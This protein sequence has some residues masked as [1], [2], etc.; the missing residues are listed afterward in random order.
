MTEAP[1]SGEPGSSPPGFHQS[2]ID[3]FFAKEFSNPDVGRG[4]RCMASF[5]APL[6]LGL[7]GRLPVEMIFA[8]M[9]AQNLANVDVRGSY[10]LRFS[11]LMAMSVILAASAALGALAAPSLVAC[12]LATVAIGLGATLWRHLS[13]DY[14]PSLAVASGFLCFIAMVEK[15]GP[16]AAESH[17]VAAL[18]GGLW[19]AFLHVAFWPIR[20]QHALR[21]AVGASW[22]AVADS[23][24]LQAN[25]AKEASLR[26]ILD[27]TRAVLSS[28]RARRTRGVIER[29]DELN[30]VAARL[31]QRVSSFQSAW[32][33]VAGLPM[34]G[35]LRSA[36]ENVMSVTANVARAVAL[37]VVSRQPGQLGGAEV[38]LR[39]LDHLVGV[40]R[41][42]VAERS[43]AAGWAAVDT[44]AAQ[45]ASYLP[46]L[47]EALR[48][49]VD[50][51]GDQG[52]FSLE[53]LDLAHQRLRPLAA[54]L[55][56]NRKVDPALVRYAARITVLALLGVW[57]MKTLALKHGYWLPFTA[58]VVLQPDYGS[59]RIRATQR[60]LGTLAGSILASF[61]LWLHLPFAWNMAATA[62]TAFGFG[63][64]LRRNY[65]IAVIYITLFV[66]V[67]TESLGPVTL[68]LTIERFCDTFAGGLL[69]LLAA[70]LFWPAWEEDR[71]RPVLAKALNANARYM[72]IVGER[73]A[74]GM[75]YDSEVVN[76]KRASESAN[77]EA[78]SSLQRMSGDPKNYRERLSELAVVAN[79]NQRVTRSLSLIILQSNPDFPIL[80]ARGISMERAEVLEGMAR[81]LGAADTP[82]VP[83]SSSAAPHGQT[84][85]PFA[86]ERSA[87][88]VIALGQLERTKAEVGAMAVAAAQLARSARLAPAAN[89]A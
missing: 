44:T 57:A 19:G 8:A 45:L 74:T 56:L 16:A 37:A 76:A 63:F 6:A 13:S 28:T 89:A 26:T 2:L 30:N 43:D 84:G 79:G 29:L 75:P 40:F 59:T 1:N 69:A 34:G 48:G 77:A 7:S 60:L 50:R 31:G 71:F 20:P 12:L 80:E 67:L 51:A 70:L 36:A 33:E 78:F 38:R 3:Q 46:E 58:L 9:A 11:L 66:V 82:R 21:Q 64:F 53:L 27:Q 62:L 23:C 17:A 88:S 72:R 73:L 41:G 55:N 47:R 49:T 54:A 65:G 39:R 61:L 52:A 83:S 25:H 18:A 86:G 42:Y 81:S 14:G 15:G 4:L 22:L 32:E 5:M 68:A 85:F 10:G 24:A 35:D 87:S